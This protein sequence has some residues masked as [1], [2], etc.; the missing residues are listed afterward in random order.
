MNFGEGL[1]RLGILVTVLWLLGV[2][3]AIGVDYQT[4]AERGLEAS[5]FWQ[6]RHVSASGQFKTSSPLATL[7]RSAIADDNSYPAK[8]ERI[9][10]LEEPRTLKDM[11]AELARRR[12]TASTSGAGASLQ[13]EE[14]SHRSIHFE[15]FE[16]DPF[17]PP[18]STPALEGASDYES[19]QSVL[20]LRWETSLILLVGIPASFWL[21]AFGVRWVILG[22]R[23]QSHDLSTQQSDI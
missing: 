8:I 5:V 6:R 12:D 20:M 21:F 15:P 23:K 16:Y 22:F 9:K 17:A 11:K 2:S 13:D 1:R 4:S 18:S 19:A 3:I 14:Q 7:S 10:K